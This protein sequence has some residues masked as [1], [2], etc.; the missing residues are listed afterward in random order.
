M[1]DE[2]IARAELAEVL[3]KKRENPCKQL[4]EGRF[5]DDSQHNVILKQYMFSLMR[6]FE[7]G[8]GTMAEKGGSALGRIS[9][10]HRD[11]ERHQEVFETPDDEAGKGL[12]YAF[13]STS[14]AALAV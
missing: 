12:A 10:F 9:C 13:P 7:A 8:F 5:D 6:E 2:V 1:A 14:R 4:P 3:E 11:R